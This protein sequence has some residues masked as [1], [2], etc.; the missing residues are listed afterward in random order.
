MA[1]PRCWAGQH[2]QGCV[3]PCCPLCWLRLRHAAAAA[4]GCHAQELSQQR[5]GSM[6]ACRLLVCNLDQHAVSA[7]AQQLRRQGRLPSQHCQE[8]KSHLRGGG[9]RRRATAAQ[10]QRQQV[11]QTQG[12]W[13]HRHRLGIQQAVRHLELQAAQGP[14][15]DVWEGVPCRGVAE[16]A[17]AGGWA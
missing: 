8:L 3:L 4:V 7:Q 6:R 14:R 15:A 10:Q 12:C 16:A 9:R 11:L 2:C 1:R 13:I 17:A 5:C